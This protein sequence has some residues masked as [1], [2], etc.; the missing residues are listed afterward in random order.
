MPNDRKEVALPAALV[1][2]LAEGV[3]PIAPLPD[4]AAAVKA[5]I[6]ERVRRE[7][8]QV[9]TVHAA[10][11]RISAAAF[12]RGVMV[13]AVYD[14]A[15]GYPREIYID[16]DASFIGDELDLKLTAVSPLPRP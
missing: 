16:Y 5:R 4:R 15:L 14:A 9:L 12:E 6:V 1:A 2:G 3:V 7:R 13:R 11:E 10:D 8:S